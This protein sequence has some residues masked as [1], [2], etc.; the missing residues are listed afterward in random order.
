VFVEQAEAAVA[1]V[2]RSVAQVALDLVD[3]AL[4]HVWGHPRES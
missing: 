3:D 4:D 1:R 2:P